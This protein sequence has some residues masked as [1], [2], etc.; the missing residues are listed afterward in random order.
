MGATMIERGTKH[1]LVNG[2]GNEDE[3]LERNERD[4]DEHEAA[5]S[6][7]DKR[8]L[9]CFRHVSTSEGILRDRTKMEGK[10]NGIGR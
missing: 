7:F 2:T 9:S 5:V 4:K 8:G 3:T 10:K 1:E 6:G